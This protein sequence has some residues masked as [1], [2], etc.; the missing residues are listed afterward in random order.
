MLPR[1]IVSENTA[2][3]KEM[4]NQLKFHTADAMSL[5]QLGADPE[6]KNGR[7]DTLLHILA[8]FLGRTKWEKSQAYHNHVKNLIRVFNVSWNVTNN[9][10]LTPFQCLLNSPDCSFLHVTVFLNLGADINTK[11]NGQSILQIAMSKKGEWDDFIET[12]V[13]ERRINLMDICSF[14]SSYRIDSQQLKIGEKL[15]QGSYGVVYSGTLNSNEANPVVIK[16]INLKGK[17]GITRHLELFHDEVSS[18]QA[19]TKAQAPNTIE[20]LGYNITFPKCFLVFPLMN[21][22]SLDDMIQKKELFPNSM[23]FC[24][25]EAEGVTNGLDFIHSQGFVHRDIKSGNVLI[26]DDHIKISD[27][28]FAI[29]EGNSDAK[30]VGTCY[31]WGPELFGG[32]RNT[33]ASDIYACGITIWEAAAWKHFDVPEPRKQTSSELENYVASGNRPVISNNWPK[34]IGKLI[35]PAW[36]ANPAERPTAAAMS[37]QIQ[38]QIR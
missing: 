18:L 33:K 5:I 11:V 14:D 26:S 3:L 28:G 27:F 15:G 2:K 13:D 10:G 36:A 21:Y 34:W 9:N 16:Y 38:R 24:Y 4:I 19:L 35:K 1:P 8:K 6:V 17:S 20:L 25:D 7:G 22:G 32:G 37:Q 23:D 12:L 29:K 31:Y 30:T